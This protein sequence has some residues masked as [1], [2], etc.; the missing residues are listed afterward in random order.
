MR[1]NW[2]RVSALGLILLPSTLVLAQPPPTGLPLPRIDLISP[3]GA[4]TGTTVELS[5]TGTDLDEIESL[6]FNHPGIKS[7]K[8]PPPP[9]PKIDAGTPP[10]KVDPKAPPPPPLNKFNVTVAADVPVGQYDIRIVNKFGISNPRVFTVGDL[11]EVQEKEPNNDTDTPQKIELGSTVNGV[12]SQPTDVDFYVFTG[13]KDQRVILSCLT[14]SIDSRAKPILELW[15]SKGKQLTS[16]R[17]YKDNDALADVTLPEDGDYF[18]RLAEFTY[19]V[20]GPQYFYRLSVSVAPWIDAIFPSVIEPG[21]P[22]Q[23]TIY[24]RNLPG[25]TPEPA[26]LVEGRPLEKLSVTITPPN[27]L[28]AAQKLSFRG[29]VDP[30]S[31]GMDGFEYRIKGPGGTS[32]PIFLSFAT[33]KVVLE[34]ENNDKQESA[35]DVP[36]PCE[37]AGRIDKRG[38]ADWYTFTAKKGEVFWIELFADRMGSSSIFTLLVRNPATKQDLA[39]LEDSVETLSTTQLYTR[40]GDPLPF[41]FV[42][43]SDGKFLVRVGCI[44]S[45]FFYGPRATYRLRIGSEKPD[46]RVVVMPPSNISPHATVI[47]A[48]GFYSLDVFVHRMDGYNGP[49][50]LTCEGLPAGV[51]CPPQTIGSNSRSGAL[52]LSAA[53]NAAPFTGTF[54]VK[55]A[56]KINGKDLVR[57]ARSATITWGGQQGQTGP[58]IARLDDALVLAVRDKAPFR[59]NLE[60]ENAFVKMGEKLPQPLMIKQGEKLTIPFKVT[61]ASPDLKQP[62]TLIQIS[63]QP[64]MQNAPLTVN[65]GAALPPIAADKNDGNFVIEAKPASLPGTYTIVLRATTQ[66]PTTDP[67][68]KGGN[69]IVTTSTM[70]ITVILLPLQVAKVT[71][72]GPKG[73]LKQ[74]VDSEVIVKVERLFDYAGELK[75]K[76]TLP[77]GAKGV[78]AAEVTIPGDKSE[79]KV[80]LKVAADAP[81]GPIQNILL[82]TTALL[83]G[84]VPTVQETKFNVNIDKATPPKK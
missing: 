40:H 78:T 9:P 67:K 38:D 33:E 19:T 31:S 58:L 48:D 82:Q 79:G 2:L 52:V 26:S 64:N 55:A 59:I 81:A 75:V 32:N 23:V 73:N 71:L 76:L 12:I 28:L 41:K 74:G 83:E 57:E 17:N 11:I 22:T 43:P 16:R 29:H 66:V 65:N 84:K 68:K 20:G 62:I 44:E 51:T 45:N 47:G 15:S 56:A 69:L 18:V 8:A 60:P 7:A 13:K 10:P 39:N 6:W 80:I 61:R 77:M 27:D 3:L 30:K 14:S 49:I 4:K 72:D 5:F 63:T 25:G 24:G 34:K 21:K 46:F 50:T 36:A 42:A 35:E 54:K 37:V 53:A 70:P 1:W